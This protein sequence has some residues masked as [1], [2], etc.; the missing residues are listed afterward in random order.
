MLALQS[1]QPPQLYAPVPSPLQ[2]PYMLPEYMG[3]LPPAYRERAAAAAARRRR[4]AAVQERVLEAVERVARAERQAR[5]CSGGLGC[6][7]L[8]LWLR[9]RWRGCVQRGKCV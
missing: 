3:Y 6:A 9:W 5:L 8:M 2:E 7:V 4:H 1:T